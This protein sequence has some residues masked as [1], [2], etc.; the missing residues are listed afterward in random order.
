METT[1][2]QNLPWQEGGE[3]PGDGLF[4]RAPLF[5]RVPEPI[6][7]IDTFPGLG[8]NR[9]G[10][11]AKPPP[12]APESSREQRGSNPAGPGGSVLA[13]GNP[14]C[15]PSRETPAGMDVMTKHSPSTARLSQSLQEIL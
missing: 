15:A 3:K 8:S 11:S 12:A 6:K 5:S 7:K 13:H 2:Q 9:A 10:G 4:S 1:G 14:C